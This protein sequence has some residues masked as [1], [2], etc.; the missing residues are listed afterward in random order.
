MALAMMSI[1]FACQVN[2]LA[3]ALLVDVGA[4]CVDEPPNAWERAALRAGP[5]DV[6]SSAVG[7]EGNASIS[8]NSIGPSPSL[9]LT[10]ALGWSTNLAVRPP[11]PG[12]AVR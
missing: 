1:A 8:S 11:S 5:N 7:S 4:D 12:T 6:L 10:L 3:H 2:D 9:R